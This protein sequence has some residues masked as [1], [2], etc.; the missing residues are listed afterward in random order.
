MTRVL[1]QT[2]YAIT[3]LVQAR[4][5]IDRMRSGMAMRA[6]QAVQQAV[7]MASWLANTRLE[8]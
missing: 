2:P 7:T 8:S 3:V 5:A 4:A 6:F 1:Y